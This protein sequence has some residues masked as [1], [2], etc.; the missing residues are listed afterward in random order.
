MF[1]QNAMSTDQK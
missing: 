1:K